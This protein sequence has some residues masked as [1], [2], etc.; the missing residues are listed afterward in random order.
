MHVIHEKNRDI[1][2]GKIMQVNE[3]ILEK[4]QLIM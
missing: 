2:E 4:E 3:V 1:L